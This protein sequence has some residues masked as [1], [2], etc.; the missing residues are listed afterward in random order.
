[1]TEILTINDLQ[2]RNLIL[3][4]PAITPYPKALSA[5]HIQLGIVSILHNHSLSRLACARMACICKSRTWDW[6][7]SAIVYL[8]FHPSHRTSPSLN[9]PQL[10]VRPWTYRSRPKCINTPSSRPVGP[11]IDR[12]LIYGSHRSSLNKIG[13]RNSRDRLFLFWIFPIQETT[14]PSD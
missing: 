9:R 1:M 7:L 14:F 12:K 8:W 10:P 5:I 6:R 2:M 13:S 4:L 3:P 11:K